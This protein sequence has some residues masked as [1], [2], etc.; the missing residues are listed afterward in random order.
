MRLGCQRIVGC[1]FAEPALKSLRKRFPNVQLI[2]LD[3]GKHPVPYH[4]EFDAVSAI[5][6]LYHLMDEASVSRAITNAF[7]AL[8]PGGVFIVSDMFLQGESA[9]NGHHTVHR[10]WCDMQRHL[11]DAGFEV[12]RRRPLYVL[13]ENPRRSKSP[14]LRLTWSVVARL[15][16][17]G[18]VV[19]A[20]VGAV[21]LPIEL[22]ASRLV[23]KGPGLEVFICR[24]PA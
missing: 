12:Q 19:G 14:L 10:P 22:L 21:L 16:R 5:D 13:M 24:K 17:R 3:I 18:S 15:A 20:G 4:E 11:S 23:R 1:D 8:R 2:N 6:V 7:Q 9:A